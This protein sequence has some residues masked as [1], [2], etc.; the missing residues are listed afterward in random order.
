MIITIIWLDSDH[1][2]HLIRSDHNDHL[3]RQWALRSF[4]SIKSIFVDFTK[5]PNLVH[6][7]KTPVYDPVN[8]YNHVEDTKVSLPIKKPNAKKYV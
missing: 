4:D 8:G 3:I 6:Y 5:F 1:N 2:D 7:F